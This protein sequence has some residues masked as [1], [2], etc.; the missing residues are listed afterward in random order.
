M[1]HFGADVRAPGHR[2]IEC[3]LLSG[4]RGDRLVTS[5]ATSPDGSWE[6]G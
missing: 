4:L 5:A 1:V 6:G 3:L 2:V